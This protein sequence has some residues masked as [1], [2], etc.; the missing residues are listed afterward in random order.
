MQR[1]HSGR[2]IY[3]HFIWLTWILLSGILTGTSHKVIISL[4]LTLVNYTPRWSPWV[5]RTIIKDKVTMAEGVGQLREDGPEGNNV[6][7][8]T[9]PQPGGQEKTNRLPLSSTAE[10]ELLHFRCYVAAENFGQGTYCEQ[11][12][13]GIS[14]T[15]TRSIHLFCRKPLRNRTNQY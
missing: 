10:A 3:P 15:K 9:E 2:S 13:S 6:S 8:Y 12:D 7:K 14:T 4:L 11:M 1:R 5:T